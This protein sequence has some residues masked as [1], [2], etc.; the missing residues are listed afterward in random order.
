[1][2]CALKVKILKMQGT[3]MGTGLVVISLSEVGL[4]LI[5]FKKSEF[6][7]REGVCMLI[8]KKS[9]REKSLWFFVAG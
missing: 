1:M 9:F 5:E 6:F 7:G 2:S 4:G 3:G 8:G